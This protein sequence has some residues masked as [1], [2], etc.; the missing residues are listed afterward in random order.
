MKKNQGVV[1]VYSY[2]DS[3][4]EA[5]R[6]LKNAGHEKRDIRV[7]SPIP[8]HEIEEALIEEESIVR[9]FT[10]AGATLGCICGIGITVLSSADWPIYVSAKPIVSIPPFMIMVFEMTVLMGALSTLIGLVV[11]ARIRRNAPVNLY[12]PRFSD[13]KFG[14]AVVCEKDR[15]RDVEKIMNDT[16]AEEVKFE[17]LH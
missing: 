12:D 2:V 14:L 10:L 11:N 13:D 1:G 6:R 4:L 8:I 7:F 17:G 3:V 16:E 15:V 5:I 9:F